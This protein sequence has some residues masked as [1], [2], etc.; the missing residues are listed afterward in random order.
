MKSKSH[1]PLR[2]FVP[3]SLD[4]AVSISHLIF[5][6][7]DSLG[8]DESIAQVA[9]SGKFPALRLIPGGGESWRSTLKARLRPTLLFILVATSIFV[10]ARSVSSAL[11][12]D[13][14]R[15][16]H[17]EVAAIVQRA[18]AQQSAGRSQAWIQG[19]W[20][21]LR[22]RQDDPGANSETE[23]AKLRRLD[24]Q[25]A[26]LEP[27][28]DQHY[29]RGLLALRS[30]WQNGDPSA[31]ALREAE[32]EI[33]EVLEKEPERAGAWND[34]AAVYL[35]WAEQ[36]DRPR[37]L[38]DA[39]AA[40]HEA[41]ELQSDF[42]EARFNQAK[43]LEEL[44]LF[45]PAAAALDFDWP[46][47]VDRQELEQ[48]RK[49][50]EATDPVAL[51]ESYLEE[52]EKAVEAGDPAGFA[53][54][55]EKFPQTARRWVEEVLL[56]RWGTAHANGDQSGAKTLLA[57]A[58][59]VGKLLAEPANTSILADPMLQESVEAIDRAKARGDVQ[60]LD[61]LAKGHEAFGRGMGAFPESV[62][63]ALPNFRQA[64]GALKAAGS[65]FAKWAIFY[66]GACLHI[67][68]DLPAAMA[69]FDGLQAD[70]EHFP[71]LGV[72]IGWGRSLIFN[73]LDQSRAALDG[74][75]ATRELAF[76]LGDL[77]SVAAV[78][79]QEAE[80]ATVLALGDDAW[81]FLDRALRI[82]GPL[83]ARY[84]VNILFTAADQARPETSDLP[85][86]LEREMKAGFAEL[87]RLF[88]N[89]AVQI[90][91][92]SGAAN[93]LAQNRIRLAATLEI[94]DHLPEAAEQ[95][96][97]AA[98]L[99]AA[100][101]D[102]V[103]RFRQQAE[104]I[105]NAA[106][107]RFAAPSTAELQRAAQTF[108]EQNLPFRVVEVNL[109]LA[110][111]ARERGDSL[112]RE[113]HLAEAQ[114]VVEGL[115]AGLEKVIDR[116]GYLAAMQRLFRARI[117]QVLESSGGNAEEALS[118][119]LREQQLRRRAIVTSSAPDVAISLDH[120]ET[121]TAVPPLPS[122][123]AY[124]VLLDLE[125]ESLTALI[126]TSSATAA[127]VL[128]IRKSELASKVKDLL[129]Q[130]EATRG[131][132]DR[133]DAKAADS[134][135]ESLSRDLIRPFEDLLPPSGRLGLALDD[136]FA[137]IPFE[138]LFAGAPGRRLVEL[139]EISRLA[140]PEPLTREPRS[141]TTPGRGAL[142]IGASE[143]AHSWG[144]DR[145]GRVGDE[146]EAIRISLGL[147]RDQLFV[148]PGSTRTKVVAGLAN[149]RLL[150]FAGHAVEDPTNPA[151]SLLIMAADG[152]SSTALSIRDLTEVSRGRLEMAIL[153][154]CQTASLGTGGIAQ[155]LARSGVL[156][157][158]GSLWPVGDEVTSKLFNEFY[159]R[160][161]AGV[162]PVQAL[163]ET[164]LT[165]LQSRNPQ[166]ASVASWA[167]FAN[168]V[169]D[170][171]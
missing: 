42:A 101:P 166:L 96:R 9:W 110:E 14:A 131:G 137:G 77:E 161:A 50:L 106:R 30:A 107:S 103:L 146:V 65:P 89:E 85:S 81:R 6:F 34:L 160:L 43:A 3:I 1:P 71:S 113:A 83:R 54:S 79:Y 53:Q 16:A 91:E 4:E 2:L 134:A 150:H 153:A 48:R 17:S 15:L 20:Q 157:T 93:F 105:L 33:L 84:R 155:A 92:G 108:R 165:A 7:R 49:R 159:Q 124:L 102:P 35:T 162:P 27:G 116:P 99:I 32:R 147:R 128:P 130:I 80:A 78:A 40:T 129:S 21:E 24:R 62:G 63:V 156:F 38:L 132:M 164:Q 18:A 74:Y 114:Q 122:D 31:A 143:P 46:D 167:A 126:A 98:L 111:R 70:G 154:G 112:E 60:G 115:A 100:N 82:S 87:Q 39:F 163:R 75:R 28:P 169:S 168:W 171:P 64:E 88:Q 86:T 151:K 12:P 45:Q 69:N 117:A 125:D 141:L 120:D 11:R 37:L 142:V 170:K 95:R 13:V 61:Q 52:L 55:A 90:A 109:I 51:R 94:Q 26:S 5:A 118:L 119:Y 23:G 149:A 57:L 121:T 136:V 148:G 158:I 8:S 56:P 104:A 59:G 25:I 133:S 58:R 22:Q 66:E 138:A 36:H 76:A 67:D 139:Y 29:L 73:H 152:E 19:G 127:R 10:V 41:L 135:L 145:L 72:R 44:G 123:A 47:W 97:L 144:L 140:I 68:R